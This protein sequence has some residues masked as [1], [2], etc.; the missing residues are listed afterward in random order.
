[1]VEEFGCDPYRIMRPIFDAVW[2]AGGYERDLNYDEEG[3]WTNPKQH[4]T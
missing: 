1:M 3:N 2:N 4:L